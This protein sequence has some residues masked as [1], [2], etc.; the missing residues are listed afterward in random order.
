MRP[1][2]QGFQEVLVHRGGGIGQPSDPPGG[3]GKY[4]DPILFHNGVEKQMKGY[5]TDIY[6]DAALEF[7]AKNQSSDRPSFVYL[8]TNA[9][10]GPYDD[11][12]EELYEMYKEM[13]LRPTLAGE[14]SDEEYRKLHDRTARILAMITNV[15]QNMGR[16]FA[17]LEEIGAYDNTLVI[18]LV[19]NGPNGPRYVR[20]LRGQKGQTLEGGIRSPFLAHWPAR[21][22]AGQSSDRIAAHFDIMPTV[23]DAAG[24][25]LPSGLRIDGRS[26][27]PL[28]EGEPVDWPER[29]VFIQSHR[30]NEPKPYRNFAA[31]TQDWKIRQGDFRTETAGDPDKIELY[32]LADDPGES[33]NLAAENPEKLR[34]LRAAYDAWF[35][36]VSSTRPDNFAP[37]R[38]P[39]GTPHENP[40][41]LTRQDWRH[42]GRGDGWARNAIGNWLI[43]VS[44]P[45]PY[46]IRCT[47]PPSQAAETLALSVAGVEQEASVAA[48]ATEHTFSVAE[49]P[50][51]PAALDAELGAGANRRGVHHVYVMK[52]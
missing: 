6:F 14:L 5:C 48:G 33:K 27:L 29:T 1:Q 19:D 4:T 28:L 8:P 37:P 31:I 35:E 26:L 41:V 17:R 46:E 16:L 32:N 44:A 18:F 51:G 36:D 15:D 22:E 11:V 10:H 20:N 49:L 25:A 42:D 13:D 45:G 23:L 40:V 24:V 34:E 7:L 3:E 21:L 52:Q 39:I 47:F 30:G 12:P 43:E 50:T 2:D 9:P 38:I